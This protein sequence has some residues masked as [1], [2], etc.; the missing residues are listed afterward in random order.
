MA[1]RLGKE[2]SGLAIVEATI[3]L[4][5]CMIIV[6]AIYYASIFLCQKAN[7]QAN[8][9]NALI[10]Y[11]NVQSD[12]FVEAESQMSYSVSG[13]TQNGVGSSYGS[14]R[15][16]FPYRFFMFNFSEDNFKSFFKSMCGNMFF[17]TGS[18]VSVE[19]ETHNYI[20]YKSIEATATQTVKPAISLSLAGVPDSMTISVSG[21]AVITDGDDLIRNV[22]FVIDIV[23]ETSVG[24]KITEWAGKVTSLYGKFK[25]KFNIS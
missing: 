9:Q 25:E 14:T 17:D 13:N 16:L 8:L 11:K 19:V 10:Y 18:N 1:R 4:P 23:S 24:K 5:V 21:E 22:D 2:E 15:G 7:L 6:I 12:S 20:I 3:L